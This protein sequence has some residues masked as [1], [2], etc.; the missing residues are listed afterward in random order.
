MPDKK[1]ASPA[2]AESLGKRPRRGG[3][4]WAIVGC[5]AAVVV[6]VGV[7]FNVWHATPQFCNAICHQ[8]MDSY[9]EGYLNSDQPIMAAHREANV[10]CLDCHPATLKEQV[11][12]A[13]SWARGDFETDARGKLAAE[14]ISFDYKKCASGGCHDFEAI[15]ASTQDWGGRKGVNPHFSHQYYGGEDSGEVLSGSM[16]AYAM[17][18]SYCHSSHGTSQMWCNGCH[19]FK[20]PDG[21]ENPAALRR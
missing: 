3:P 1:T 11:A 10:S 9:V 6:A 20:T 19:D 21:W 7:G 4:R 8:P 17:D 13:V 5:I 2:A 12:E 16:G 14:G 18:C 15:A